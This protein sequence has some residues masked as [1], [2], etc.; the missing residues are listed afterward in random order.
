M[1]FTDVGLAV[2]HLQRIATDFPL[3]ITR[4]VV[5]GHSSGGHLALWTAARNKLEKGT[6][7][8]QPNPLHITGVVSIAGI[9]DLQQAT[10]IGICGNLAN[11]LM[12][13]SEATVPNRYAQGS[14]KKL[15]PLSVPQIF[16]S[17][18]Q[19]PIV[20]YQYVSNYV[21]YGRKK[22]DHITLRGFND[23]GHFEPVSTSTTAGRAVVEA[24]VELIRS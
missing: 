1:T 3:N 8:Y 24:I 10:A 5:A 7:L 22:G 20:P 23:T 2:D 12:G 18:V 19:D 9:P 14:P 4:V 6:E 15:A 13:G 11:T 21:I 17:G 16:V